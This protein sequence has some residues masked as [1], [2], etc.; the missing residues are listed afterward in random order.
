M[1]GLTKPQHWSPSSPSKETG[2]W[3]EHRA[4]VAACTDSSEALCR[5]PKTDKKRAEGPSRPPGKSS[6]PG[7][8]LLGLPDSS[9]CPARTPWNQS[10][11]GPRCTGEAL[12][13]L[14]ETSTQ[15]CEDSLNKHRTAPTKVCWLPTEAA[16]LCLAP[17]R[18]AAL[19]SSSQ[20]HWACLAGQSK[21]VHRSGPTPVAFGAWF[22]VFLF[23]FRYVGTC[24]L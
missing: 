21:E 10:P 16:Q 15:P 6:Q 23:Y 2:T 24:I 11:E 4:A 19:F 13:E 14:P 22:G 17:H 3:N 20:G 7:G 9:M 12:P 1:A 18:N 8:G 5:F